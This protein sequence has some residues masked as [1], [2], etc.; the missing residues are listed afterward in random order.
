MCRCT[1]PGL[2]CEGK[3][4]VACRTLIYLKLEE[5]LCHVTVSAGGLDVRNTKSAEWMAKASEVLFVLNRHQFPRVCHLRGSVNDRSISLASQPPC[6]P[7]GYFAAK[8]GFC[9]EEIVSKICSSLDETFRYLK[10]LLT[11]YLGF[12]CYSRGTRCYLLV[13]VLLQG[14]AVPS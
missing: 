7:M 6:K 5:Q 10:N 2:N 3:A 14:W 12:L 13:L 4:L 8:L 1:G 9:T 11:R